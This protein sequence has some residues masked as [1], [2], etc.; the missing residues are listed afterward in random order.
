MNQDLNNNQEQPILNPITNKEPAI[1]AMPTVPVTPV[2]EQPQIQTQPVMT[3]MQEGVSTPNNNPPKKKNYLWIVIV[4]IAVVVLIGIAVLGLLL[5]KVMGSKSQSTDTPSSESYDPT[6]TTETK[7]GSKSN[8]NILILGDEN[9]GKEDVALGI[10]DNY[11]GTLTKSSV[12]SCQDERA[13]GVTISTAVTEVKTSKR[14]YNIISNCNSNDTVKAMITNYYSA[15]GA[16]LVVSATDGVTKQTSEQ[17]SIARQTGITRVVVFISK[18]NSVSDKKI[19][20][21]TENN[22]QSLL[23]ENGFDEKNTPIIRGDV[24]TDSTITSLMSNVDKWI[25]S[26][27]TAEE[28][29]FAMPVEDVFAIT[30]RGTVVTG[31]VETGKVKVDDEVEII[32]PKGT[33]KSTV[34]GIEHFRESKDEAVAGDNVGILL[35]G[36]ERD[37]VERGDVLAKSGTVTAHKK[38]QAIVYILE[39]SEGG[40]STP[41]EDGEKTQFYFR[42]IDIDGTLTILSRTKE[43]ELGGYEEVT[44]EMENK[45][46]MNQGTVFSIREG[47]RT[48]GVGTVTK[49]LD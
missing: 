21:A 9:H 44:I 41:L 3:P 7:E 11:G 30:G 46:A 45:V 33:R 28:K 24:N 39:K 17:L 26:P 2:V 43:I 23:K 36:I 16:I 15:D 47:G 29:D 18:S 4:V 22:I 10:S 25:T 6:E 37:D 34:T 27:Q 42:T 35:E 8:L 48:I 1:Q 20:D 14:E 31:R 19:L 13:R 49:V 12:T 40:R 38:F 32:G 5:T